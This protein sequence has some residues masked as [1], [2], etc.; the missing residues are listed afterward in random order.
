MAQGIT[1]LGWSWEGAWSFFKSELA[2]YKGRGWVVARMTIAASIMMLCILTFRL[3]G[4]ALGAYYTLVISRDST[5]ATLDSTVTI[6]VAIT[7]GLMDVLL[8]A[9]LFAGSPL[10]HFLSVTASLFIIF[11][12]ISAATKYNFATSFG[13]LVAVTIPIWDFPANPDV[14]LS[15]TLYAALAVTLGAAITLA[16][17]IVFDAIHPG[18]L[19]QDGM[20]DRLRIVAEFLRNVGA[21]AHEVKA[22]LVQYA[23]IGTGNLRRLLTRTESG[24][25]DYAR[26]AVLIALGGRLVDL[27]AGLL[28]ST[29]A[30]T[31]AEQTRLLEVATRIDEIRE[32]GRLSYSKKQEHEPL[33][34]AGG[35]FVQL[36]EST[37][38]LLHDALQQPQLLQEYTA[39]EDIAKPGIL[40]RDAFSNPAHL[41]FALRGTSAAICCYL[42]YHLFDW[43]GLN[44]SVA[45]CMITA[46]STTG[47]SRQK[48]ILRVAGAITG[49]LLFAI[50][51]EVFLLP[52]MDSISEFTVLFGA[53]TVFSAWFATSSPR[54]SYYGLQVAFAFYIVQLRAFAPERQ[55][56]TARDN[57]AGILLGLIAMWLVF[58]QL[59][60]HDS[61]SEMKES[62][63]GSIRTLV[64]Y[65]RER[66]TA[67]YRAQYLKRV[68]MF[69]DS[70]NEGFGRVRASADAV[71]F[72]F[73]PKREQ[74]LKLRA[75]VR[76]WQP[77]IRTLFLLQVTLAH[78][79]LRE[80][81]GSLPQDVER[82]QEGCAKILDKIA[83]AL[84][85][86]LSTTQFVETPVA[87]RSVA[88]SLAN[89]SLA[90]AMDL[91]KQVESTRSF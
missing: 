59:A 20:D 62:L 91:L 27:C 40:R 72:E 75:D 55:L 49:G 65:M 44:S 14:A 4:A 26:K 2:P 33:Q 71:L 52:H 73:G 28:S 63:V 15:N 69:R 24:D 54:L 6:L 9:I 87:E 56:V 85:Q 46:L 64:A 35:G 83:D 31:G 18:G 16:V 13:F 48:Q 43:R 66:Q 68:R 74:A 81:T 19:M 86:D 76:A 57:V 29:T 89:D 17:E 30:V 70:I 8:S 5:H 12:L 38:Q 45:T 60:P 39:R 50:A 1:G 25:D 84:E 88:G 80:P 79:R 82:V 53:V 77:Q 10:L 67:S 37:V 23:D 7:F 21:P 34:P 11:F 58:D 42:A 22:K 41:K 36:L 90:I 61:I 32:S 47:S 78:M 51:A 3:P